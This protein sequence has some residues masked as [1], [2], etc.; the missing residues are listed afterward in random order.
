MLKSKSKKF[1]DFRSFLDTLWH[2]ALIGVMLEKSIQSG[3]SKAKIL[4]IHGICSP[5][6]YEFDTGKTYTAHN[7]HGACV[8]NVDSNIVGTNMNTILWFF[9]FFLSSIFFWQGTDL[10]NQFTIS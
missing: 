3:A 8:S 6:G 5:S 2:F 4:K 1:H 7:S 9:S 10:Y